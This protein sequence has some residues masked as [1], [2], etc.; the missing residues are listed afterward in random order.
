MP[1]ISGEFSMAV[2]DLASK[3]SSD[4]FHRA[5][6]SALT[7]VFLLAGLAASAV[8]FLYPLEI[9]TR[10]S[11][12]WLH[13]L[14]LQHGVN[15][16]DH[17]QVAFVNTNH[18]PFDPLFKLLV[19][20]LLPFLEAWQVARFSVLVLPYMFLFIAW[21]LLGKR[22]VRSL[23]DVLFLG[24]IGYLFLVM[25]AKEFIFVGRSD[26]TAAL[27]LLPLTYF[28]VSF[29]PT[30]SSR[31][32]LYGFVWGSVGTLL[33]LTNW[34]MLPVVLAL[35]LFSV[36]MFW[37]ESH[38][39]FRIIGIYLASCVCAAAIIFSLLLYH[40]FGFDLSL[41]YKHF[42]GMYTKASGHGHRTYGHASAIWFL[43]SLL[44]PTAS[45]ESLKG[46]PVLLALL[47]YLLVPGKASVQNRA[48]LVLGCFVF[49]VC[50]AT[51][52]L[53][54][55]GGGQWY[56]IPFLI[57][58][59][60]FLCANYAVMPVSRAVVLGGIMAA[61]LC[62]NINTVIMPSLWRVS[63][64]HQAHD[65]MDQVR[66]LE[67]TNSIL[68]EDTF[69]F[70][71]SYQRELIDMGDMVSRVRKRGYYG[72]AFNRTVDAHFERTQTQPPDYIV[73]GF[74]ESPELRGFIQENYFLMS[75]GPRNFTA[76]GLGESKLFK[77]RNLTRQ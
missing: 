13:V 76:N 10:E 73:T 17:A 3:T 7:P 38:A 43:G 47:V 23:L 5:I 32:A 12:V 48:W 21:K 61:F 60:F 1:Q 19:S 11:T 69:F 20:T 29:S 31:S 22:S 27:L 65:F 8:A 70:R 49:A 67:Q 42:F 36:W 24:S 41:Y 46:G 52:Y 37:Y 74:T 59:W 28:S 53:N 16:Y 63:T 14:A 6:V 57:F 54:Y 15:I 25:S 34:R 4:W 9:E 56:Y 39:T 62:I 2:A 35:L 75:Q 33:I 51:Y 18:G 44:K 40:S 72:D 50:T 77:R 55:Y 66:S 68:S 71:T 26:A 30:K 58:L 64:L 45:P